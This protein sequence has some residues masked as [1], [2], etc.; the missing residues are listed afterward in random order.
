MRAGR[1]RS[2]GMPSRRVTSQKAGR[3]PLGNSVCPPAAPLPP[4]RAD[5]SRV[6]QRI[7]VAYPEEGL[8][9]E[10]P[11]GDRTS[12]LSRP[13][14]RMGVIRMETSIFPRGRGRLKLLKG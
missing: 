11:V 2:Q 12:C 7:M 10:K 5:H 14:I 8:F 6:K 13:S 4:D 3:R 9:G 1:P